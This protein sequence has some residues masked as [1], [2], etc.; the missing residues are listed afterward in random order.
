MQNGD[1]ENAMVT[2]CIASVLLSMFLMSIAPHQ[3]PR[4]LYPLLAPLAIAV[5]DK[6]FFDI[7]NNGRC[8]FRPVLVSLWLMQQLV[9][10]IV[11]GVLHQGGVVRA[12]ISARG[13]ID[14]IVTTQT[15]FH[16]VFYHTYSLPISLFQLQVGTIHEHSDIIA[17][18]FVNISASIDADLHLSAGHVSNRTNVDVFAW[19]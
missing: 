4:F 3:E 13:N 14:A 12:I 5:G 2:A 18:A 7:D 8:Q 17:D 19:K 16:L 15:Q 10:L 1:N 6:L 11:F 9:L